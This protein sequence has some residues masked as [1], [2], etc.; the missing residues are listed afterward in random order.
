M[1]VTKGLFAAQAM[2]YA[3]MTEHEMQVRLRDAVR[4][5][6]DI[7]ARLQAT[8]LPGRLMPLRA[9]RRDPPSSPERVADEA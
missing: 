6:H 2:P 8:T 5:V 9:Q 4:E 3:A 1:L 7:Q